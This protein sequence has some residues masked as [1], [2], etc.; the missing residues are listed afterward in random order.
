[1]IFE[2]LS[3]KLQETLSKLTKK[4]KLTEKDIDKILREIKLSLLEADVNFKVVKKFVKNI[5]E[6]AIGEEILESLTPG[7]Q[8]I[9][10][11]NDEMINLLGEKTEDI[12][13]NSNDITTVMMCGLQG[14]GKTTTTAKLGKKYKLKNKNPLFVACDVYRPAAV[15]Q[16]QVL[17]DKTEIDVFAGE[18]GENPLNIAKNALK[19]AKKNGKDFLLFDTAGRLHIDEKMMKELEDIKNIINPDEILLVLDSMTGQEAVNIAQ[20]FDENLEISGI[21]LSKIDGDAR[22]GAALSISSIIGKPIKFVTTGEKLEDIEIFHPDRMASRILGKGDVL[23]LIEK[24]Q[25]SFDEKKAKELEKKLMKNQFTFDD[26]LDQMEQMQNLGPLDQILEMIPGANSK[27]LK[28]IKIDEKEI[29]HVKA[30]IQSMTKEERVKPDIINGSRRKRIAAG[31]G[32]SIQKVNRLLRQYKD[33]KKMMK[34]MN[35]MG[36]MMSGKKGLKLPF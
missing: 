26:F 4:G 29:V 31:S 35:K 17:G 14:A 34:N 9:K 12:K 36:N 5:K 2:S 11:V 13:V 1:M 20:V 10:I 6:K 30:I 18:E 8:V 23:S 21:I 27:K 24:A 3:N 22:G 15:K 7:Q 16:L 33:M 25:S 28:N 19:Y 32:T